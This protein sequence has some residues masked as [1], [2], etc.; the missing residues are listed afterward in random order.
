MKAAERR[1]K[2]MASLSQAQVPISASAL[3]SQFGVSR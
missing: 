1:Q 3:A 2:I